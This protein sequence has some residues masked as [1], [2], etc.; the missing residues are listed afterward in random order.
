VILPARLLWEKGVGEFVEAARR[1]KA[2]G[3]KARF[4][5]VG[6]PDSANPASVDD[7]Q[8]DAWVREGIVEAWGWRDD[9][10]DVLA[11]SQIA[12]LPSHHEGL[13]KSLLEA[14]ASG[15]AMVATDIPGCREIVRPGVTG[16]LVP[17]RNAEILAQAL[18][19]AI[20]QPA[21]RERY[22]AAARALIASEFSISRVAAETM[23]LYR[24]LTDGGPPP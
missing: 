21:L 23:A 12:C 13:P 3:I 4:A 11:Q 17:V 14:A 22:G 20:E 10:V 18:E 15:C 19:E 6:K 16:W 9:M 1:L 7:G 5:L 2:K 24:E 8:V